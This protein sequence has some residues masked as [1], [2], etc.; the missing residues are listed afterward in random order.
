MLFASSPS[1]QAEPEKGHRGAGPVLPSREQRVRP[2]RSARPAPKLRAR[3]SALP[4]RQRGTSEPAQHRLLTELT[5][6]LELVQ[7]SRRHILFLLCV[8]FSAFFFSFLP[9]KR[10]YKTALFHPAER[11]TVPRRGGR[12]GGQGWSGEE[13][14]GMR[15]QEMRGRGRLR[16]APR[17]RVPPGPGSVSQP[18]LPQGNLPSGHVRMEKW[19]H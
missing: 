4:V 9:F 6:P 14:D 5:A 18:W 7:I 8:L 12:S 2:G 16:S 11:E 1:R 10:G 17:V 19:G 13:G 3:A 15:G